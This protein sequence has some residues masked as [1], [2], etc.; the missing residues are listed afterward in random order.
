V[1]GEV[2]TDECE[3]K[4]TRLRDESETVFVDFAS[5]WRMPLCPPPDLPDSW[6]EVAARWL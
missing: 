4:V 3:R 6:V 2:G 1:G 5:Q